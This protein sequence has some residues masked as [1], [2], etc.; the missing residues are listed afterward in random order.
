MLEISKSVAFVLLNLYV[1]A[2]KLSL[3]SHEDFNSLVM[4]SILFVSAHN[5]FS[6]CL[7]FVIAVGANGD[8][9]I[10][11]S[12]TKPIGDNDVDPYT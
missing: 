8:A 7:W 4:A 10:G 6:F 12:G 3:A 9:S 11:I 2:R 1:A 5:F